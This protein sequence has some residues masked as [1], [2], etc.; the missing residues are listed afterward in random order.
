MDKLKRTQQWVQGVI[1]HP[2]GI[3]RGAKATLINDEEWSIATVV[4]PSNTLSSAQRIAIYHTSYFARLLECFKSEYQGL[5]NALGEELFHHLT[6]SFL[7]VHPSTTYTLN[8]LG[9][10]F[11][12][13]LESTLRESLDGA[14][15]DSWQIFIVDMARYERTY[16]EVYNGGGHEEILSVDMFGLDPLT[17][18]P[19]VTTLKLEFPIS[20][21]ID[22]FRENETSNFPDQ[23]TSYYIINRD[24]YRVKA[25]LVDEKEWNSLHHWISNPKEECPIEYGQIWQARGICYS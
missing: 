17:L 15:P 2:E 13:Y 9:K 24:R 25:H 16:T 20:K 7:Q 4:S 10:L 18:S 6:W 5:F 22:Q 23:A 8:E 11:P 1:T 3:H 12:D 14:T 21:C 19:S